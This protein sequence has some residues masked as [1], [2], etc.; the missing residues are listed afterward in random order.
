[1]K[2]YSGSK[3]RA[4][5]IASIFVFAG[6][7][8]ANLI[9]QVSEWGFSADI[10]RDRNLIGRLMAGL[11]GGILGIAVVSPFINSS[12][13]VN[14]NTISGPATGLAGF[15]W[16]RVTLQLSDLNKAKFSEQSFWRKLDGSVTIV[17]RDGRGIY[18]S[19]P[20]F[21]KSQIA[22]I[23]ADVERRIAA[24]Q[25]SRASTRLAGPRAAK[26]RKAASP[27]KQVRK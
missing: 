23:L 16:R 25:K 9:I 2:T 7:I 3:W 4:F 11:I 14:K 10:F 12:L 6:L 5:F 22:A 1:M 26:P 27:R 18:I 20:H 24:L 21:D 15:G 13:V 19:G 17:T 8:V